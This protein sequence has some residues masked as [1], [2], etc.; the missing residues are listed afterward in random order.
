MLVHF[1]RSKIQAKGVHAVSYDTLT[2]Y[3]ANWFTSTKMCFLTVMS[4]YEK[5]HQLND[6][7]FDA[8]QSLELIKCLS[9]HV[10]K[11]ATLCSL[12]FNSIDRSLNVLCKG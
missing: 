1:F 8:N 12:C 5:Y 2:K 3:A 9:N 11:K 10:K 7:I 4:N 6:K